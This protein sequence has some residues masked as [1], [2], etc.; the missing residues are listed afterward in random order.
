MQG[1][2][3]P[4]IPLRY[5]VGKIIYME[6]FGHRLPKMG[7]CKWNHDKLYCITI[8]LGVN[9]EPIETIVIK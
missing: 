2:V 4:L 3:Q 7:S 8:Q 5:L 6:A 1:F 9:I